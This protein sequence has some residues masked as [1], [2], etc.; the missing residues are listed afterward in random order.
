M[1]GH[2]ERH[3]IGRLAR[4]LAAEPRKRLIHD[5]LKLVTGVT[6]AVRSGRRHT[7]YVARCG[8]VLGRIVDLP[9][10]FTDNSIVSPVLTGLGDFGMTG[11]FSGSS[12][13]VVYVD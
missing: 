7:V 12:R 1:F 8:H 4:L 2:S 3:Y 6:H 10:D 5:R 9:A 13:L 11:H